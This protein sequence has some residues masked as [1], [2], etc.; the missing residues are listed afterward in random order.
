[1]STCIFCL[2]FLIFLFFFILKSNRSQS[3]D[4]GEH[5]V[6]RISP[7]GLSEGKLFVGDVVMAVNNLPTSTLKHGEIKDLICEYLNLDLVVRRFTL[8]SFF[9]ISTP[10][11]ISVCVFSPHF[12]FELGVKIISSSGSTS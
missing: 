10:L 8:V 5:I 3:L 7:G 1:M 6:T 12:Y 11:S 9:A 2:Y 4:E